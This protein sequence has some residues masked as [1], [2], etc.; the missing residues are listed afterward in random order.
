MGL[1]VRHLKNRGVSNYLQM[2]VRK[3]FEYWHQGRDE[4]EG[5]QCDLMIESLSA[6]LRMEVQ[7]DIRY[8]LINQMLLLKSNFSTPFLKKLSVHI[9]TKRTKPEEILIEESNI[10][11]K[12][13][14]LVKGIVNASIAI[15]KDG[16]NGYTTVKPINPN[17]LFD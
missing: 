12:L 1:L 6:N 2:Q 5:E 10:N 17:S 4:S 13:Y 8:R 7:N 3:Y 15:E 14:Y 16:V 9:K 11:D